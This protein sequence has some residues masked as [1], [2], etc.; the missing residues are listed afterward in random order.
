MFSLEFLQKNKIVWDQLA[1]LNLAD[2]DWMKIHPA[3]IEKI[4]IPDGLVSLVLS[5]DCVTPDQRVALSGHF[6]DRICW[7]AARDQF[8]LGR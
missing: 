3:A 5:E 2:V 6:G 7:A 8:G 1:E 4:P